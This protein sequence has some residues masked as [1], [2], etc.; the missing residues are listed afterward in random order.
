MARAKG[1]S[2]LSVR[3]ATRE[4]EFV[5][6]ERD[7]VCGAEASLVYGRRTSSSFL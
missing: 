1:R 4:G 6:S 2:G 3:Y 5:T 7:G